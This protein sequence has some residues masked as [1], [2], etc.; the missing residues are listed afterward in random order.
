MK[1]IIF[2]DSI[3]IDY[4]AE[5]EFLY[6]SK[7][8]IKILSDKKQ[9]NNIVLKS[10]QGGFQSD[11]ISKDDLT[12]TQ[13][14][15]NK[16]VLMLRNSYTF[17]KAKLTLHNI[18]I[19]ENDNGHFNVPHIHPDADFSGVLY[20][21]TLE[22]SGDIAFIRNDKCPSMSS[23]EFIFNDSDFLSEVRLTPKDKMIILFPSYIQHMVYPNLEND[24]RISI[25]FNIKIENGKT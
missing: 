24:S 21:K 19:N 9:K 12:L 15:A 1:K 8:I 25:S 18:W 5:D 14:L 20:I 4:L 3:L 10:N 11:D 23:H 22:K 13:M 7:Q 2:T 16:I 6:I 17:D